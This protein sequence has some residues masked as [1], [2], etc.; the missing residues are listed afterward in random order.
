MSLGTRQYHGLTAGHGFHG[1]TGYTHE[2]VGVR[3]DLRNIRSGAQHENVP[4]A[5]LRVGFF[6][7][8]FQFIQYV[9]AADEDQAGIWVR[10][11]DLRHGLR[12][13]EGVM[14]HGPIHTG[15]ADDLVTLAHFGQGIVRHRAVEL[16]DIDAVDGDADLVCLPSVHVDQVFF[17]VVRHRQHSLTGAGQHLQIPY[18]IKGVVEGGHE[19]NI[20]FF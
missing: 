9:A 12:Q 17:Q 19:G 18:G 4:A 5:D 20:V 10:R 15:D 7:Q 6:R 11:H 1:R 16:I 8:R 2:H 3:Q 14:G 13:T